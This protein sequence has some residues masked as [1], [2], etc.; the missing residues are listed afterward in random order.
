MANHSDRHIKKLYDQRKGLATP[1]EIERR[2]AF[3]KTVGCMLAE[4]AN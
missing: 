3:W 2:I 1:V 4:T